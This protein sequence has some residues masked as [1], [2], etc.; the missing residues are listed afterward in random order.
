MHKMLML[1]YACT[2]A[3]DIRT[4]PSLISESKWIFVVTYNRAL[5]LLITQAVEAVVPDVAVRLMFYSVFMFIAFSGMVV[6]IVST[7]GFV[8]L[9]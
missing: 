7:R 9:T 1:F 6:L 5:S 3:M 2:L 8:V 4:A